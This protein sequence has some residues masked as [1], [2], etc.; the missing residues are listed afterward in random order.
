MTDKFNI[1][2]RLIIVQ[3]MLTL[4]LFCLLLFEVDVIKKQLEIFQEAAPQD[5][6]RKKR[7]DAELSGNFNEFGVTEEPIL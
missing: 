6:A 5:P 1:V 2:Y 3:M 7:V 4:C